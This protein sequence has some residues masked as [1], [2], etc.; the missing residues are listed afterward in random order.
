MLNYLH[1][2]IPER[3]F[4]TLG[5]MTIYKY[6]LIIALAIIV[7]LFTTSRI[8]KFY[9]L[10]NEIVLDGVFYGSIIGILGARIY[11]LLL[12]LPYYF[13][14]PENIIKIWNGGLA[15]HGAIIGVFIF[16]FVFSKRKNLNL[17]KLLSI[18][19]PGFA[20]A[21]SI[22]RWGNYFN[23]ELFGKPTSLPWGIP[24]SNSNKLV[25]FSNSY[26][27]H[28]TFLYESLG[29][30]CIF[31]TL[32]FLHFLKIKNKIN[33]KHSKIFLSYLTLYSI[34]RFSI[35]F[36][37]IDITH[38]FFSLRTPQITSLLLIFF[39]FMLTSVFV[40]EISFIST[41]RS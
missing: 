21:Q 10:K 40:A 35:E 36:I 33:I 3:I 19:A 6:G 13:Q 11:E 5:P 34:L 15:I 30:F 29:N 1:T 23:Q 37:K 9:N 22:G 20:I 25:E 26:F 14:N 4:V 17:W 2:N 31:L 39:S 7:L 8:A 38:I 27:F 12:E 18:G 16:L 41:L 32:I 28:P 24:I